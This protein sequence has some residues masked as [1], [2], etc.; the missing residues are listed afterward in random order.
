MVIH[1]IFGYAPCS[2]PTS[3]SGLISQPTVIVSS[4]KPLHPQSGPDLS[5]HPFSLRMKNQIQKTEE[6]HHK[7]LQC[8]NDLSSFLI[9]TYAT[10]NSKRPPRKATEE[11]EKNAENKKQPQK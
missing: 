3:H 8:S 9:P 10:V 5:N 11:E 4:L 6:N 1:P 2:S 7:S